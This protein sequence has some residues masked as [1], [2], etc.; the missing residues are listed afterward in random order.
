[1]RLAI[2]LVAGVAALAGAG[3]ASAASVQIRDAVAR[4]TVIPENRRDVKVEFLTVNPKLP[5]EV[6]QEGDATVIDGGLRHRIHECHSHRDRPSVRVSGVGFV[7]YQ[8]MPQVVIR[9]PK[10]VSLAADG[11]VFGAIGRSGGLD[12]KDSGCDAWTIADV[13]GAARV[14]E[15]GEGSIRM[16]AA[17]RL[18][19]HLS[20]AANVHAV[21]LADGLDAH[22]S[23]A[24][25][26]TIE[27]VGGPMEADISGVGHVKVAGGHASLV[28][29]SVSGMGGVDFGGSADNLEANISGLGGVHVNR[30]TGAIRKS[31][32][33]LG[34][35]TVD[36]PRS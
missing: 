11:A 23:G 3:A 8:A 21:R 34:H 7:D 19:L 2:A 32:S 13:A 30:V 9:T 26:V 17:Q 18:D 10:D 27:T 14:T 5:L 36:Q 22:L 4:V 31:V 24:G 29:A 15:S 1:M 35:V 25:G 20:G 28:R 12:L 16:G 33:G 6:R